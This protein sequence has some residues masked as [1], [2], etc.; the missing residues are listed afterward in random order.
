MRATIV[1]NSP[2]LQG[3]YAE[4]GLIFIDPGRQRTVEISDVWL[5]RTRRLPFLDVTVRDPLDHD[6]DG[7]PGGVKDPTPLTDA[8]KLELLDA[9]TVTELREFL[10][11]RDGHKP[12]PNAKRETLL[13]KARGE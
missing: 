9:M 1:N 7:H 3:V 4:E 8:E 10:T 12:H 6:G 13:A 5:E 11:E 2:A